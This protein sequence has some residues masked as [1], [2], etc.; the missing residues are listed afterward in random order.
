MPFNPSVKPGFALTLA[1]SELGFNVHAGFL[2]ALTEEMEIRPEHIGAASSGSYVGGLYAAGIDPKTI[3]SIL[4][5]G[6]MTRSFVEWLIPL[7][8]MGL[9]FN[10][11]GHTGLIKGDKADAYLRQHLGEIQI[12]ECTNATLSLAVTNLTKGCPEIVRSGPL[13]KFILASCAV[14]LVFK[15]KSIDGSLYCDGAVSDSSPFHHFVNDPSINTV[16]VHEVRHDS[17]NEAHTKPL[18]ISGVFA[19]SHQIISDRVLDLCLE[20]AALVGKRV[21]LLTSVVPRYRWGKKGVSKQLFEAG[22]KTVL[23]NAFKIRELL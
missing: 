4:S 20:N 17:R 8:G 21:L 5:Q 11:P 13:V 22:R 18:T 23:D 10:L 2:D 9:L 6:E 19:R 16:L 14:P 12:E 15:G 7:R 1:S 3:H